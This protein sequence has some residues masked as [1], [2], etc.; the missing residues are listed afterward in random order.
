MDTAR[1]DG[2]KA[3][4]RG[5]TGPSELILG[6]SSCPRGGEASACRGAHVPGLTTG[7]RGSSLK[8][9]PSGQRTGSNWTFRGTMTLPSMAVCAFA[10][11]TMFTLT[12]CQTAP[13]P[14]PK[15]DV[16]ADMK[17]I[18]A[19]IQQFTATC[20][21]NDPAALAAI[22]DDN[23]IEMPPNIEGK[24]FIQAWLQGI[25]KENKVTCTLTPLETQVAGD[26]AYQRGNSTFIITP[27]SG[28]PME[29]S[30]K[31]LNIY[32]RQPDGSWKFYRE[33]SNSNSPPPSA[34]GKKK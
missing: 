10:L 31:Y 28:K 1:G 6:L 27:K 11:T 2:C 7:N 9:A 22:H 25:F 14:E 15:R 34:T 23:A 20:N 5:M 30:G 16:S 26:W 8:P 24:Q 32:R 13:A 18:E 4:F 33:M 21:S 29:E 19:L 3:L 12:G 17:A